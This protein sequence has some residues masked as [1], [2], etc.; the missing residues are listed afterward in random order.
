MIF[1]SFIEIVVFKTNEFIGLDVLKVC[2]ITQ[3]FC[4]IRN[5]KNSEKN[6][7]CLFDILI[8]LEKPNLAH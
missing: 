3:I 4:I 1:V 2:M 8:S 6:N 7:F 5:E